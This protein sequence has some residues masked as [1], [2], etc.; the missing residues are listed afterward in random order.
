MARPL[1][2]NREAMASV[3]AHGSAMQQARMNE[4]F[5]TQRIASIKT[6]LDGKTSAGPARAGASPRRARGAAAAR[7]TWWNVAASARPGRRRRGSYA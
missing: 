4:A 3:G 2:T 5:S 7:C 1:I 6:C